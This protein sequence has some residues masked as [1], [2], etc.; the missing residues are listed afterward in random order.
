M[1]KTP[2]VGVDGAHWTALLLEWLGRHDRISDQ[3]NRAFLA[4]QL[5]DAR[6]GQETAVGKHGISLVDIEPLDR[7][8]LVEFFG[9][10][11]VNSKGG[12]E[13]PST[14]HRGVGDPFDS[15]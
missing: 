6:L 15:L 11:Q 10:T 2:D 14:V 8:S 5:H 3:A 12:Q 9:E 1:G 4:L 13:S 7:G